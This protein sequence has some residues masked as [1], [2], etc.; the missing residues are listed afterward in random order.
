MKAIC[1]TLFQPRFFYKKIK[2]K[3]E[4]TKPADKN[5]IHLAVSVA[6]PRDLQLQ[7]IY[8]AVNDWK[9]TVW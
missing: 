2:R 8:T 5:I 9:S 1:S 4:R 6:V 7:N 3:K